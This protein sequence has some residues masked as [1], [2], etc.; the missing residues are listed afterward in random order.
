MAKKKKNTQEDFEKGEISI[1]FVSKQEEMIL[2]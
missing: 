2:F 1:I